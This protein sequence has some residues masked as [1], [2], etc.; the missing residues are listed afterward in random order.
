MPHV[1]AIG[2]EHTVRV[3]APS[4]PFSQEKLQ[5]GIDSLEVRGFSFE[6]TASL[7]V[8][9]HAY[10]NGTDEQRRASLE[11]AL[12]SDVD[13][14][15]CARGGYGLTRIVTELAFPSG[16]LPIVVGFS[17]ATALSA[18][19]LRSGFKTVHGPLAT[20]VGFEPEE[21]LIHLVHVL[22][23][24]ATGRALEGLR[25]VANPRDVEGWMFAANLCV[26]THLIGT[27]NMPSFEGA[28][29]VLEEVGE[30]PYRIDRQLT[31]LLEAGVFEG[32]S[33]FVIGQMVDC[34]EPA[35]PDRSAPTPQDIFMERL[36][37]LGVPLFSGAPI[38]HAAPNYAVVNGG[39]VRVELLTDENETES[40]ARLVLLEEVSR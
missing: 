23:G 32:V 37:G 17:D 14:V 9:E 16:Q 27:K 5:R 29:V 18:R 26:L 30:R 39:K 34:D 33:A 3:V 25:V 1:R 4:S 13:V 21:S 8:G 2:P 38:G 31:H 10:L 19:L 40:D 6:D 28:V 12:S 15:W 35:R 20:T 22:T 11:Q 36:G 24:R 7:L